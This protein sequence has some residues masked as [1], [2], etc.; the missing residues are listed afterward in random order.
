[1]PG[2]NALIKKCHFTEDDQRLATHGECSYFALALQ[3]LLERRSIPCELMV[4]TFGPDWHSWAHALIRHDRRYFD[5]RGHV[6]V[7]DI[8]HEF[9]TS[10]MNKSSKEELIAYGGMN[11]LNNERVAFWYRKLKC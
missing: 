4:A 10:H 9:K 5:I 6:L 8:H 1:V 2:V 7:K 11:P 3:K